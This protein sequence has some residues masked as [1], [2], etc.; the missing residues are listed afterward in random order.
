[1]EIYESLIIQNNIAF[2]TFALRRGIEIHQRRIEINRIGIQGHEKTI[3]PFG[4]LRYE[5]F[6]FLDSQPLLPFGGT[7]QLKEEET[8][9]S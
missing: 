2:H 7:T 9:Q 8:K 1:M 4:T 5:S 3:D 6:V